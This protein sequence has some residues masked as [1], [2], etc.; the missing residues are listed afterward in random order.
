MKI[1]ERTGKQIWQEINEYS[2]SYGNHDWDNI[3]FIPVGEINE[4]T[5]EQL[6]KKLHSLEG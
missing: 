1:G 3:L 4:F 5:M 2:D 6:T